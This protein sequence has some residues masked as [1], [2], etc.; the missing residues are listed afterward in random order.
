MA[1]RVE[2][3]LVRHAIAE[4]RGPKW[5]DDTERPLTSKGKARFREVVSALRSMELHIDVVLSS[6]LVRARQTAD[7]LAAGLEPA[8]AVELVEAL[9]PGA[10]PHAILD[11]VRRARRARVACV[12]HEPDLGVAAAHFIG[13]ARPLAFKKGGI[14]RIDVDAPGGP[15]DLVWFAPPRLL[16][17]TGD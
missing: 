7:L 1:R 9:A 8:P 16:V 3:Y 13:A 5:P 15:G 11:A 14:C 10:P 6:P 17:R 2:L 4:E 12:G